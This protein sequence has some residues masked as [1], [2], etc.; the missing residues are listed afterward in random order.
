M[1][2]SDIELFRMEIFTASFVS[3]AMKTQ[4]GAAGPLEPYLLR[5]PFLFLKEHHSETHCPNKAIMICSQ[6]THFC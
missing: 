4:S 3:L 6:G 5:L 1:N 2:Q